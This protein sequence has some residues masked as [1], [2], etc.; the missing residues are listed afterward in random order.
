MILPQTMIYISSIDGYI[1]PAIKIR[2][3]VHI[4]NDANMIVALLFSTGK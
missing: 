1:H 2:F 3:S 4:F